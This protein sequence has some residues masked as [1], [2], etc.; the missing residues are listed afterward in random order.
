[1]W[2]A[3]GAVAAEIGAVGW[4]AQ[5]AVEAVMGVNVAT[6]VKALQCPQK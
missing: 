4:A 2:D 6:R 3:G 1:M 5:M